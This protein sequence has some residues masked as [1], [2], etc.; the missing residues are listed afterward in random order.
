VCAALATDG[1][2]TSTMAYQITVTVQ[3]PPDQLLCHAANGS[4]L[5]SGVCVLPDAVLG[6][7]YLGHLVTSHNAGGAL[8]V[9]AGALPPGL[10]LP[11]T[12]GTP[13]AIIGG[14]PSQQGTEPTY[15]FTVQGTGDQ[16][17]PLYQ[18]YS[19]TVDQNLALTINLPA[20]G[21]TL[22]PGTAGQAY[23]QDFFSKA[24]PIP[25]A[26]PWP[27]ASSRPASPCRPAVR[28][29]VTPTTSSPGRRPR[30]APTPSR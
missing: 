25:L 9:V 11:A 15:S 14:T 29:R 20:S 8:S 21:S 28:G 17:Q 30:P 27:P 7:P 2:L 23:A 16:G 22:E 18:S 5:I 24:G 12:F 6:L 3:G 19:I 1:N 10:S 13:G 4:F 26:G